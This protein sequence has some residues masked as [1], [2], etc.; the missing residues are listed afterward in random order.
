VVLA[1]VRQNGLNLGYAP[2]PLQADPEI[3]LAAVRQNGESL[4][5]ASKAL[6]KQLRNM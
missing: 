6:R 5:F 2:K 1:A 3:V 4:R